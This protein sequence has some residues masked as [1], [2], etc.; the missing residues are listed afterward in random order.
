M[1]G[2]RASCLTNI[3]K[4]KIKSQQI[5]ANHPI[6]WSSQSK[7]RCSRPQTSKQIIKISLNKPHLHMRILRISKKLWMICFSLKMTLASNKKNK[8]PTFANSK[9][10]TSSPHKFQNKTLLYWTIMLCRTVS[11]RLRRHSPTMTSK[12]NVSVPRTLVMKAGPTPT[13]LTN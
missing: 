4:M 9:W 3:T 11:K 8:L 2:K 7:V 6:V 13:P 10:K 12:R 5:K 1:S